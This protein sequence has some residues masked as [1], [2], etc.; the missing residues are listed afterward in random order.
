MFEYNIKGHD[1]GANEWFRRLKRLSM[2]SPKS[3]IPLKQRQV[4]VRIYAAFAAIHALRARILALAPCS[5]VSIGE[6][7]RW[8]RG[9]GGVH[10][11]GG[12]VASCQCPC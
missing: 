3:R 6:E 9:G 11:C 7:W 5:Q 4:T 1:L 12:R 10:G 8:S 2:C